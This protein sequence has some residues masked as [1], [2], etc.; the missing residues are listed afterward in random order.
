[1]PVKASSL[2]LDDKIVERKK[3]AWKEQLSVQPLPALD[4]DEGEKEEELVM[5]EET[6]TSRPP[7]NAFTTAEIRTWAEQSRSVKPDRPKQRPWT[8]ASAPERGTLEPWKPRE[9]PKQVEN[10]DN[11]EVSAKTAFCFDEVDDGVSES[12]GSGT[13]EQVPPAGPVRLLKPK[14][15]IRCLLNRSRSSSARVGAETLNDAKER[16][17]YDQSGENETTMQPGELMNSCSSLPLAPWNWIAC[18]RIHHKAFR[19]I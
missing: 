11:P 13:L 6:Q 1:M 17:N 19:E 7:S 5:K 12:G 9:P 3:Q 8:R 4:E 18:G 14:S 2:G 16:G 10:S 15:P